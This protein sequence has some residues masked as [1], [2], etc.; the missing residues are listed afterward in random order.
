MA[1]RMPKIS[2]LLKDMNDDVK[3]TSDMED[4]VCEGNEDDYH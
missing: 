4:A 3:F 2:R 1:L